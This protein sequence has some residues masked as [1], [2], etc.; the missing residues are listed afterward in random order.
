VTVRLG[1]NT[2]LGLAPERITQIPAA[3]AGAARSQ[4]EL[5]P[6]WDGRASARIADVITGEG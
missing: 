3:L 6:M 4:R 1:T 5:P 2:V